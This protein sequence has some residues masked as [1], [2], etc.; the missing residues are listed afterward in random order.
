MKASSLSAVLM[1][2]AALPLIGG[3]SML[4]M[5]GKG[6]GSRPVTSASRSADAPRP[7][8][9]NTE[10]A[11]LQ[12]MFSPTEED[13]TKATLETSLKAEMAKWDKDGDGELNNAE[14]QP[15]NQSLSDLNVGASP[16]TDWNGDG[17][18]NFQEFASGWRT[19]F[20]LCDRNSDEMV[21]YRELG[22]SPGNNREQKKRID[23][24]P[25]NSMGGTKTKKN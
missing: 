5:G 21:S 23:M 14:L 2:S 11:R 3:C 19:M 1:I 16:V 17:R 22:F 6:D 18:V 7:K 9:M 12:P 24:E 4:G 8:Q 25:P 10:C 15:L 13:L 20:A